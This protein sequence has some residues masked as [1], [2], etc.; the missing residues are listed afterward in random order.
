MK[1]VKTKLLA[2][3]LSL[4]AASCVGDLGNSDYRDADSV[5]PVTIVSLGDSINAVLGARLVLMPDIRIAGD[6]SRYSYLWYAIE[7]ETAGELPEKFILGNERNLNIKVALAPGRY[8]L[9]LSVIDSARDIFARREQLVEVRGT[10]VSAGWF[11]LKDRDGKTD[12]D[13]IALSG[14]HYPD[15]L[16]D[17]CYPPDSRPTGTAVCLAYQPRRYYHQVCDSNGRVLETLANQSAYYVLSS[18]DVRVVNA[19]DLSL[20]KSGVEIFYNDAEPLRPQNLRCTSAND[21]V[22]L[23]N[24]SRMYSIYSMMSN[25]GKFGSSKVGFY[26]FHPDMLCHPMGYAMAFDTD[27]RTF[28]NMD[29]YGSGLTAFQPPATASPNVPVA[30]MDATLLNLLPANDDDYFSTTAFAVMKN[31]NRNEYYLAT[32]MYDYFNDLNAYPFTAFDTIPVGSRMPEAGVK[33]APRSGEFVYFIDGTALKVYKNADLQPQDKEY[34]LFAFPPDETP[35]FMDVIQ[36]N[37]TDPDWLIVLT[38]VADEWK[39]YRFAV[40]SSG[41]AELGAPTV[42]AQGKG[43]ARYVMYRKS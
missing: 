17:L 27:S 32:I 37:D 9:N 41:N 36:I 12:F 14:A 13:Y 25:I 42:V 22:F 29:A 31:A 10:D 23:M 43:N 7:Y 34:A 2:L 11:V 28:Y 5:M 8:F 39:L 40:V 38:N 20:F 21:D 3:I 35:S 6:E 4:A 16:R 18:D 26:T 30:D 24:N 33:T 19:K 15:V 1:T